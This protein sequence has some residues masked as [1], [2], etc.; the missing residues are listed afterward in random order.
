MPP[1]ELSTPDHRY[2]A[3]ELATL[4]NVPRRTLRYYIQLGLVD[5]PIGET[6]AAVYT[7]QHLRQLLE[8]RELT[9]QGL[10]LE[11]IA[12]RR[13]G[14]PGD[15]QP[16]RGTRAGTLTGR[17]HLQLADGVELV[18][19]PGTARLTPEQLRRFAR[20]TLAAYARAAADTDQEEPHA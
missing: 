6:R 2:D 10:S 3:E 17:T 20:E 8:V 12:D 19:E 18:V 5:R 16:A 14:A 9:E 1:M 4:A 7:W 13:R 15:A 11:Q